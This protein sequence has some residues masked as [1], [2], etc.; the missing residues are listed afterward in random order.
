MDSDVILLENLSS[1]LSGSY[2]ME[3]GKGYN[4]ILR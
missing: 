3:F 1:Y 4:A 2:D